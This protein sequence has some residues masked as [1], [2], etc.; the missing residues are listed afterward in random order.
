MGMLEGSAPSKLGALKGRATKHGQWILQRP[1][2]T[3]LF[4]KVSLLM[5]GSLAVIARSM[6]LM[7]C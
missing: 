7:S 4:F 2:D 6:L 1:R 5:S 3:L